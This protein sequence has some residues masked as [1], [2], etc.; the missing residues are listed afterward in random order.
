MWNEGLISMNRDSHQ[1]FCHMEY[2]TIGFV[3]KKEIAKEI[4]WGKNIF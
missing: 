1:I 3:L 2:W 4:S